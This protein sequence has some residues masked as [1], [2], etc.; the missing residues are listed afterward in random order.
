MDIRYEQGYVFTAPVVT[1]GMNRRG[2][3]AAVLTALLL[4][5][6]IVPMGTTSADTHQTL[7]PAN[8]DE[9]PIGW[10][11]GYWHNETIDVDQSDGLTDDELDAYVCRAMSRVE[12]IRDREFTENVSVSII[13]R[14]E[15]RN[16]TA[17]R[18]G[19]ESFSAWNNQVWEALFLV[20]QDADIQSE[21]MTVSGETTG[22]QYN[23]ARNRIEI[24]TETPE[25]PVIDNATLVH[26]LVHALQDQ[27][28]NFTR[29]AYRRNTQDGQL[30]RDGLVEGEANY[31]ERL[32]SQRCGGEW[33]CVN[34]PSQPRTDNPEFHLGV[35][36]TVFHPYSD[37]PSYVNS[38][39][40]LGGWERVNAAFENPPTSTEQ[41]IHL[42]DE[43]PVPMALEDNATAGWKPF[44]NQGVNGSDTAGEAS[45]YVM[46][47]YQAREYGA[48]TVDVQSVIQNDDVFSIYNY[49][50]G[51][52]S[53]W[54]NDKIVPYRNEAAAET[55]Y[56]YIWMTEWDTAADA[57]QFQTTYHRILAAHDAQQIR[58]RTWVISDGPFS[59][60]YRVVRNG[61]RVTIVNAPT[62]DDVRAIRPGM[63]DEPLKT[64]VASPEPQ[65]PDPPPTVNQ[66]GSV[67]TTEN[68]TGTQGQPGFGIAAALIALGLVIVV[69]RIR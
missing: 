39:R 60:T 32:Y 51:P 33:A 4:P 49:A 13:S 22:G 2:W 38:L 50:A 27:H 24:I 45:V 1:G 55:A 14:T 56:G 43:D 52:S 3:S 46:F 19:N 37:G 29:P 7:P 42:T 8:P 21:L 65:S 62:L 31:I 63:T 59:D 25:R 6:L 17:N 47:W 30:S 69:R 58:Q 12:V 61:T 36:L 41:I 28:F 16:R 54:G 40:R 10:E 57:E 35:F 68:R 53:G 18:T 15:Y 5:G 48:N 11:C 67:A 66:G 64:P 26:E 20:G 9:D 34:T 23:F 44:P